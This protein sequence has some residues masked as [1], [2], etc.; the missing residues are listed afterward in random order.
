[1]VLPNEFYKN[2][3]IND[4]DV[5]RYKTQFE[6]FLHNGK[7]QILRDWAGNYYLIMVDGSPN[8]NVLYSGGLETITLTFSWVEVGDP[9]NQLD[10]YDNNLVEVG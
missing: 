1:M 6:E 4:V 7:A 10:L 3:K 2:G 8:T 5:I 9:Y